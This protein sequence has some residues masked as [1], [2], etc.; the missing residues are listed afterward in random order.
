MNYHNS[1]Q[2]YLQ[3]AVKIGIQQHGRS[4]ELFDLSGWVVLWKPVGKIMLL[5]LPI[6]L[7]INMFVASSVTDTDRLLT[8]VDDQRHELMDKNMELLARKARLWSPTNMEQLAGEKL[9]LH[10]SAKDQVGRYS[11]RTGSFIYP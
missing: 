11:S 10:S 4:R 3:S 2:T 8:A 9:A 7:G 5:I 1:S 6:I